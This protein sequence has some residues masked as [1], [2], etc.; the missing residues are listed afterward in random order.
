M[1]ELLR[2]SFSAGPFA[3][4]EGLREQADYLTAEWNQSKFRTANPLKAGHD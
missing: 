4:K 3:L 1:A 2:H